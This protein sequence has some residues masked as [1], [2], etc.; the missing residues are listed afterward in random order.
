MSRNDERIIVVSP[1]EKARLTKDDAF[2]RLEQAQMAQPEA[3][4]L[5]KKLALLEQQLPLY[6]QHQEAAEAL[7][8][9]E[10]AVTDFETAKAAAEAKEEAL[11][12]TRSELDELKEAPLQL[13]RVCQRYKDLTD[14]KNAL[15]NWQTAAGAEQDAAA[16][17]H[18]AQQDYRE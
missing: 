13:A 7:A 2:T 5:S 12:Q 10:T 4:T 3:E 11:L 8:E 6:R 9:P 1:L 14:V 17:L 15:A 16:S 18:T